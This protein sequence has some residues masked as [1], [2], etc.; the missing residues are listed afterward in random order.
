MPNER[1]EALILTIPEVTNDEAGEIEKLLDKKVQ[2]LK[3]KLLSYDRWG[4]YQ[5]AYPIKKNSYG[6]YY[7]ARFDFPEAKK[8]DAIK[9]IKNL[10]D[11]KFNEVVMRYLLSHLGSNTSLEYKR[12]QSLDETPKDVDQFLKDNKMTGIA[13]RKSS[14]PESKPE[15]PARRGK[16]LKETEEN[17]EE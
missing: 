2:S 6:V 14:L 12:P 5:L 11:L 3:G 10:F 1:Y 16:V 4:K 17:I 8:D 9:E 7:L 15:E 13:P